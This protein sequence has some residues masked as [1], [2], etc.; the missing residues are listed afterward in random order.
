MRKER[1]VEVK[2]VVQQKCRLIEE[3]A[4]CGWYSVNWLL[5]WA[6]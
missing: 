4:I 6:A 5:L 1:E 2:V 3:T